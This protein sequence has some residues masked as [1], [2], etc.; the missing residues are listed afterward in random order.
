MRELDQIPTDAL[1]AF[2]PEELGAKILFS[3]RSR[4]VHNMFH[5]GSLTNELPPAYQSPDVQLAVSEAWAW[6][7]AQGFIV[8][9]PGMNGQNGWRRLSR[10][11]KRFEDEA[12]V[13]SYGV[14][15]QVAQSNLHHAI[16]KAV[17]MAFIRGELDVAV[18]QALKAVEVAVR[19]AARLPAK[20]VGVQL[21]RDAFHPERGPLTDESAEYA[22]REARMSLFAGAIGSYKNPHSHRNV[23]LD[24]PNEAFEV[25]ML[26][27]HLLRIVDYRRNVS[28]PIRDSRE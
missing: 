13:H 11:A 12:A 8:P 24:D 4:F 6:L 18:F 10:R 23:P 14:A 22:E 20:L 28:R 15:T 2:E 16:S 26:A 1:L 7:E 17:W 3:L 25:I 9:E 21:M 27:N 19:E 5:P